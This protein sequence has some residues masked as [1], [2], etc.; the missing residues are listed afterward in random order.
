[1]DSLAKT[2]M[3]ALRSKYKV[4]HSLTRSPYEIWSV[5]IDGG[6]VTLDIAR[7]LH[8]KVCAT[9]ILDYYSRPTRGRLHTN[10]TSIT[11]RD[12]ILWDHVDTCI[13]EL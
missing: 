13:H 11:L 3:Q 1:M 8:D 4:T 6:K 12:S 2:Y 10:D 5:Y 7:T 9:K